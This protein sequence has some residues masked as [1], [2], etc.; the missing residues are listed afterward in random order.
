MV[1]HDIIPALNLCITDLDEV[2]E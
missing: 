1:K 2:M